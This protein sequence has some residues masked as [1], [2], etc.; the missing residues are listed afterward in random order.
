MY[1]TVGG[2]TLPYMEHVPPPAEELALLDREL[3]RLDARRLQLL[4]RRAWLLAVL[5]Q[6]AGPPGPP[7][8]TGFSPPPA[9]PA[10][11]APGARNVLLVLGGLLLAVAAIAF[12]LFSWGEMGIAGRSAVLAA[13][14]AGALL[15]PAALLRRGLS[16][17]AEA[18]AAL[19][20][21]LTV[22]DAYA[23]HAVAAPGTDGLLFAAVAAAVLAAVWTVYGLVLGRLRLALPA[24][25]AAGQL[26]LVLGAWAEGASPS[27]HGWALLVTAAADVAVGLR[28]RG[29]A[30]RVTAWVGASSTGLFALLVGLGL[31]LS[32]EGP[33]AS[34]GPG[35]LLLACAL[36]AVAGAWRATGEGAFV[37]GAVG[38]LA[39]VAA[40]GGVVR[41]G[42][43]WDWSVVVYLLCGAALSAVVLPRVPRPVARGVTA[44]SAV[45]VAGAALWALPVVAAV[46]LG[47]FSL[48]GRVWAGSPDG[49]R[50]ALGASGPWVGSAASPVVLAVVAG[51]LGA[52]YAGLPRFGGTPVVAGDAWRGAAGAGALGLLWAAALALLAVADV[53]YA[54]AV[55]VELSLVAGLLA[56]TVRRGPDSAGL[57]GLV[58][59]LVGAVSAGALALA[60]GPATLLVS[61]VLA[62]LCAGAA[63]LS[64]APVVR[65]V[66]ACGSVLWA[67]AAVTAGGLWLG[68]GAAGTAPVVLVVPAAAV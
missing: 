47:P 40:V 15:A 52:L 44:A 55:G 46:L 60:A 5:R 27:V 57:S 58:C 14:T 28:G 9:A 62:L 31:S 67:V 16:A 11:P 43:A 12:T 20:L 4:N 35:V 66:L 63:A 19:A 33:L 56:V 37:A 25:V 34:L 61:G 26:P 1:E 53:P 17:T 48:V 38:G 39:A 21:V 30:V 6:P 32:A 51:L 45:V 42:L 23:V 3:V 8:P 50:D 36:V 18:L 41:A 49:F 68:W 24:A 59:A 10:A 54:V 22:L 7:A 65:S 13:V 2:A 29:F 64:R